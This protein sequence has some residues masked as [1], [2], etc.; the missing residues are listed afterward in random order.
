SLTVMFM[1]FFGSV[2]LFLPKEGTLDQV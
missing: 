1:V 2:S